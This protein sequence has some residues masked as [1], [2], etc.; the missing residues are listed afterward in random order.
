MQT[1]FHPNHH[2]VFPQRTKVKAQVFTVVIHLK[3][4]KNG[5]LGP[6]FFFKCKCSLKKTSTLHK[7]ASIKVEY[8]SCLLIFNKAIRG[9]LLISTSSKA[10]YKWLPATEKTLGFIIPVIKE[11]NIHFSLKLQ[12]LHF[13]KETFLIQFFSDTN[14]LKELSCSQRYWVADLHRPPFMSP[15]KDSL[16][17][18]S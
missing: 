9:W 1:S 17:M 15:L 10:L 16:Q 4:S 5:E 11:K 12:H 13:K 2:E 14:R 7:H 8:N 18:Y 6:I 3:Q